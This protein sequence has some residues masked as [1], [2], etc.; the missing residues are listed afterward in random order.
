VTG[1][2]TTRPWS[3]SAGKRLIDVVLSLAGLVVTA[4]LMAAVALLVRV[5]MGS[6][7]LFRQ[8]R[9]G[10][11]G[12]LFELMKFRTMSAEFT[13]GGG[14]LDEE[15]RITTLGHWLRATS[16]DELPELVH[17]FRGQ[18]SVVGPRP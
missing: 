14:V 1:R 16:L 15:D 13:R 17:I 12:Q 3:S 7:V 18:M 8:T 10:L 4:P 5:R 9:I 2:L 11:N 6:P